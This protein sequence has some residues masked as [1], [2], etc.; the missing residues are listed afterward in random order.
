MITKRQKVTI[1]D[2]PIT[3]NRPE[4]RATLIEQT[5]EDTGDGLSIWLVEFD[6][7][8]GHQYQRTVN[9]VNARAEGEAQ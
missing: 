4:G 7:A 6:G 3:G 1:Y 5:H 8:P 9:E 2:D